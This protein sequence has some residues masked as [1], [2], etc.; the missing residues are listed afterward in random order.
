MFGHV[1]NG[2]SAELQGEITALVALGLPNG[3]APQTVLGS[4]TLRSAE[5]VAGAGFDGVDS[6]LLVSIVR[7]FLTDGV[8]R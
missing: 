5:L 7:A 1:E 6:P 8:L 3:K 2:W 4:E